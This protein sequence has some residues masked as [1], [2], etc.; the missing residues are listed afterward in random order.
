[1]G[2]QLR[3][4]NR[5]VTARSSSPHWKPVDGG[6]SSVFPDP[7]LR[8][9]YRVPARALNIVWGKDPRYWQWIPL[10]DHDKRGS[11]F[12]DEVAMLVQFRVGAFGWH[13]V[14]V[15]F[16]V[17]QSNGGEE[18]VRSVVVEPY[19]Q[20]HGVWHEISG[21]EF[22]VQAAGG[23]VEFGMYEIETEW[24][25]GCMVLAGVKIRPKP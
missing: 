12:K 4:H 6:S 23:V 5:D 13:S 14:P 11:G 3:N 25:K 17:K 9:A 24:W 21:G 16:K 20:K 8:G 22:T 19:R 7:N 1:M 15:K 18:K 10:S 2:F